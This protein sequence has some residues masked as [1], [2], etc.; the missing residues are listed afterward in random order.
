VAGAVV[1]G[2]GVEVSV[3]VCTSVP[4][5]VSPRRDISPSANLR[6]AIRGLVTTVEATPVIIPPYDAVLNRVGT[7]HAASLGG[8]LSG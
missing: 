1:W 2:A 7:D 5:A 6:Q 3:V 4:H 8:R